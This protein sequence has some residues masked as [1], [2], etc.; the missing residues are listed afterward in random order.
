MAPQPGETVEMPL[1]KFSLTAL[2]IATWSAHAVAAD[3]NSI[4][5]DKER[6]ACY[7]AAAGKKPVGWPNSAGGRAAYAAHLQR[8]LLSRGLDFQAGAYERP[9]KPN[10]NTYPELLV[11]APLDNALVYKLITE[12]NVLGNAKTVGFNLVDFQDSLSGG[13]WWWDIS[14]T[15]LPQCDRAKRLCL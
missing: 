7:D 13:H 3:C 9:A 5:D 8:F 4:T 15:A 10:R 12:T 11:F 6:L 1:I 2:L 14:G